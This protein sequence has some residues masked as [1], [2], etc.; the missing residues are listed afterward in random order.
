MES[1]RVHILAQWVSEWSPST[2]SNGICYEL[3]R[4]ADSLPLPWN[5]WILN[6]MSYRILRWFWCRWKLGKHCCKQRS[7]EGILI[8]GVIVWGFMF[9]KDYFGRTME[10]WFP[11]LYSLERDPGSYHKG[12]E[13]PQ[14]LQIL[15]ASSKISE[16]LRTFSCGRPLSPSLN[17]LNDFIIK[18][19]K[20][21]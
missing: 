17:V 3:L 10:P 8:R 15:S 7:P 12:F 2:S 21:I 16:R 18:K 19:D 11:S 5:D 6:S 13:N 9:L 1:T 20:S 4:N 14:W